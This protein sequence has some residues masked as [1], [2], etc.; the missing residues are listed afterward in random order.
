M[1]IIQSILW[2]YL[3]HLSGKG[4]KWIGHDYLLVMF[5]YSLCWTCGVMKPERMHWLDVVAIL[6]ASRKYIFEENTSN[7]WE[8]LPLYF[9][10]CKFRLSDMFLIKF[11]FIIRLRINSCYKHPIDMSCIFYW[12][13]QKISDGCDYECCTHFFISAA[14]S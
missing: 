12:G 4:R 7:T 3:W 13:L 1:I 11:P 9:C 10:N 14:F 5:V 2:Y 6:A 8:Y